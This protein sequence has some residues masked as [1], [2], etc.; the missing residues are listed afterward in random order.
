MSRGILSEYG[1]D[2]SQP[3]R[4]GVGCGGVLPGDTKD[5]MNY[6]PPYG[7]K[8]ITRGNAVGLG[9]KNQGITN[10]PDSAGGESGSPGLGGK[11]RPGGSQG[12]Y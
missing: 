9:G 5:V 2:S 8:G 1:P 3:Q 11:V 12:R 4:S 7:P 6:K 10:G